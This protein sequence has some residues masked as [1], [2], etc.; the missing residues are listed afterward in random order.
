[1]QNKV[2]FSHDEDSGLSALKHKLCRKILNQFF[3]L[4]TKLSR[5]ILIQREQKEDLK[6]DQ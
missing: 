3:K 4:A 2:R 1:M 6:N 5:M